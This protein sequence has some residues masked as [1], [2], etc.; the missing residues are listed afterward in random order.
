MEKEK[1]YVRKAGMPIPYRG[2]SMSRDKQDNKVSP[3]ATTREYNITLV[4]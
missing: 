2:V 1:N 4:I 3:S